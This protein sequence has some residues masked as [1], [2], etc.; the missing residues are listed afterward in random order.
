MNAAWLFFLKEFFKI[1]NMEK[2]QERKNEI[3]KLMMSPYSIKIEQWL[4]KYNSNEL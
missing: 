4:K 3:E 2:D 1:A